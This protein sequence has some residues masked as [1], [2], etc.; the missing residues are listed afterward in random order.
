MGPT[1]YP[2]VIWLTEFLLYGPNVPPAAINDLGMLPIDD[3][4]REAWV[5]PIEYGW[6]TAVGEMS[7]VDIPLRNFNFNKF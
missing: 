1:V 7:W 5:S 2:R 4:S 6:Q 3:G